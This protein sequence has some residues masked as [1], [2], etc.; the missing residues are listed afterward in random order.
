MFPF[1][2]LEISLGT[3]NAQFILKG[4]NQTVN[5]KNF[6]RLVDYTLDLYTLQLNIG[7]ALDGITATVNAGVTILTLQGKSVK[8]LFDDA[9]ILPPPGF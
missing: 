8:G 4:L 7:N 9:N 1:S 2:Q 3:I 5:D 6:S